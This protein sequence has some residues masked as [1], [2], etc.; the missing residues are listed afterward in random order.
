MEVGVPKMEKEDLCWE[1]ES[2]S[3][4]FSNV[5]LVHNWPDCQLGH[6]ETM[7]LDQEFSFSLFFPKTQLLIFSSQAHFKV[8]SYYYFF[9]F[10]TK[11]LFISNMQ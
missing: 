2:F 11:Q 1:D 8:F 6:Q 7:I 4:D 10:F 9:F 5:L 3:S